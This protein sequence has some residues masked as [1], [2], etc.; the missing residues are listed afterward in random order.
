MKNYLGV[1]NCTYN[2]NFASFTYLSHKTVCR[3]SEQIAR[4]QS[5]I[6]TVLRSHTLLAPRGHVPWSEHI[7]FY[8]LPTVIMTL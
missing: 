6:G 4:Q 8:T 2:Q 7:T 1:A 3:N 5:S